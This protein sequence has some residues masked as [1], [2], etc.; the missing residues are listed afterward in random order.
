MK[1]KNYQEIYARCNEIM[2]DGILPGCKEVASRG[3][4]A[5]QC[6][7]DGAVLLEGEFLR[8]VPDG[9]QVFKRRVKNCLSENG[10]KFLSTCK[11]LICKIGP[12]V[13]V[14]IEPDLKRV[15]SFDGERL[16]DGSV[17]R[18]YCPAGVSDAFR[19]RVFRVVEFLKEN[20]IWTRSKS[21]LILP[22]ATPEEYRTYLM[23]GHG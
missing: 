23:A 17:M 8:T 9:V 3:V 7:R 12:L 18:G 10:C 16:A 21:K 19:R 11:P 1:G 14:M 4:C 13:G 20:R 15:A 5:N 2:G 6:C 22:P